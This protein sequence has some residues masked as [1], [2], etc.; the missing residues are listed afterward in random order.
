MSRCPITYEECG[1]NRYSETGLRLLSPTLKQLNDFPYSAAVQRREA[2]IHAAKMSIQGVQPKLSVT[3]S[4]KLGQ[5]EIVDRGGRYIIKPQHEH[6][7]ELP[8]NEAATIHMAA[9]AGIEVPAHGLIRCQDGSLSYFIRR[10]DRTGRGRKLA[11]E[12]FAQLSGLDRET[13]YRSSMERVV[14]VIE[15]Y[16]TFPV[17]EKVQLLKRCLFNYLVGNEDM[18]LKNFSLITRDNK[19]ELAP[20]YDFLSTTVAYLAIGKKAADIEETALTI[21][22]RKKLS[23]ALWLDYFAKERLQLNE[24]IISDVLN[25]LSATLPKWRKLLDICFLT[26]NQKQLYHDLLAQ[27]CQLLSIHD[28]STR[29][30]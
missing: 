9:L 2:L 20:A 24:R 8:E 17:I 12:D 23:R 28:P 25:E 5:F 26:D 22:G 3:L 29:L 19:V 14:E 1:A 15:R 7:P 10:F 4:V 16:C 27:R 6:F 13:K 18:H 21:R 30:T 11:T